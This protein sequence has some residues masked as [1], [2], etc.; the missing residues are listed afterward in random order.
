[1]YVGQ[2]SIIWVKYYAQF[3]IKAVNNSCALKHLSV[4]QLAYVKRVPYED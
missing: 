2:L 4:S 1:M 3:G